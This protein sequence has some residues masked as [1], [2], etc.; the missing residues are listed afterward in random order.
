MILICQNIRSIQ[1]RERERERERVRGE[2][3][4]ITKF[5][6]SLNLQK[7]LIHLSENEMDFK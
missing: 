5:S 3:L 2:N 6:L 4:V 7:K 1:E